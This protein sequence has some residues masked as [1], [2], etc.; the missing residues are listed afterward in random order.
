[1]EDYIKHYNNALQLAWE[2]HKNQVDK[3]GLLY[4]T[5]PMRVSNNCN[6]QKDKIVG[7]L[8]DVIEDTN[9]TLEILRM[10]RFPTEC[11]MSVDAISRRSGED[12]NDYY[13]R[14]IVDLMATRVKKR[15]L[16]DNIRLVRFLDPLENKDLHRAEKYH[17]RIRM[18]DCI[19]EVRG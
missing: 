15:D 10:K 13:A 8:H 16:E 17:K 5:H 18:I 9:C 12:E 7:L 3:T 4:I 1:M 14:L 11:V 2:F 6:K 19:L